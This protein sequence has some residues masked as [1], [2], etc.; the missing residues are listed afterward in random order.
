MHGG[1]THPHLEGTWSLYANMRVF[2]ATIFEKRHFSPI[3]FPACSLRN[4]PPISSSNSIDKNSNYV[5]TMLNSKYCAVQRSKMQRNTSQ[6]GVM[7]HGAT[8][9]GAAKHDTALHSA[10]RR[11][12]TMQSTAQR[13]K[14]ATRQC[15]ARHSA[16]NTQHSTKEVLR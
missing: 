4:A 12:K 16:V 5:Y 9:C 11:N 13:S 2:Y 14:Y 3:F 1:N 10:V 6:C 8:Q 7:Q 15:K